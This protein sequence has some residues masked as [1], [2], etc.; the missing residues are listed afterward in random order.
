[1]RALRG[2]KSKVEKQQVVHPFMW[3]DGQEQGSARNTRHRGGRWRRGDGQMK[4]RML[5][6][7]SL[8]LVDIASAQINSSYATHEGE[9]MGIDVG[10]A[11]L[12]SY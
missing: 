8:F 2:E 6:N 5:V 4:K 3:A 12:Q 9:D 1:V 10:T 11:I 7:R